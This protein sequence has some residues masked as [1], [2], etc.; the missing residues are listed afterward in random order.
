[1]YG[2]TTVYCTKCGGKLKPV[3]A[4]EKC[5]SKNIERNDSGGVEAKPGS[6]QRKAKILLCGQLKKICA[7]YHHGRCNDPLP[8]SWQRKTSAVA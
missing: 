6:Q 7:D 8:C 1:M 2:S 4:C 5:A 3:Y